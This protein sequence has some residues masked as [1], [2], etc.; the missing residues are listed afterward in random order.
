MKVASTDWVGTLS[1]APRR[2]RL[3]IRG[4]VQAVGFRPFVHGLAAAFSG[5]VLAKLDPR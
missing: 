2:A 3:A 1:G 4:A 5:I